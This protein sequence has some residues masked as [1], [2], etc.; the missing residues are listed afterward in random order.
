MSASIVL[1]AKDE[2]SPSMKSIQANGKSL[3]RDFDELNGKIQAL[4][5][6]NDALNKSYASLNTQLVDAKKAVKD[7][8]AAYKEAATEE[9]KTNLDKATYQ[10]KS[11]T[12]QMKTF[13][14]GSA[15]T[16]KEIRSLQE[17][18]RKLADGT[19]SGLSDGSGGMFTA[20]AKAGLGQM[21]GQSVQQYANYM[22]SS[23]FD[24]QTGNLISG[25]LGSAISGAAIGSMIPGGFGI[26]IGAAVGAASGLL[27]GVTQNESNKDATMQSYS[28]G[29][30]QTSET[31]AANDLTSGSSIAAQRQQDVLSFS[32]LLGS[33]DA[34][35]SVLG[36]IKDMANSTPYLYDDLTQIAK[37]LSVYGYNQSN[38]MQTLKTI[39][40]TGSALSMSTADMDSVA[41]IIGYLGTSDTLD[42]MR[43]KQLRLKGIN[44]NQM[45]QDY[46]GISSTDLNKR[47]SDGKISGSDAASIILKEMQTTFGGMMQQQSETFTGLT[48][49]VEGLQQ[50]IQN[51]K[52]DSFNNTRQSSLQ[53][54][55]DNLSG[56]LGAKLK[57]VNSII[58]EAEGTK[59]N[60][61]Q[62]ILEDVM[63]GVFNGTSAKEVTDQKTL[64]K[65][66]ELRSDYLSASEEYRTGD[67][68]DRMEAG[69][70]MDSIKSQAE[71]L[72]SSAQ[73]TNTKL[74]VWDQSAQDTAT[75]VASIVTVLDAWRDTW[76]L[77]QSQSKGRSA[78]TNNSGFN[79]T[80]LGD[81]SVSASSHAYG[82]S[83][84]PYD[85]FPVLLHQ[86]ERVLT[87]SDARA[88][89]N[90]SK[91]GVI[92]TITGPVTVRSDSDIPAV[93]MALADEL[94]RRAQKAG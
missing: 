89:D 47:V 92:V 48:S 83:Y 55:I 66:D 21:V 50:E 60:I 19:K 28:Q 80:G 40:D 26:P 57:S 7:A 88:S 18:S 13:K 91:N 86:G 29:L 61:E 30:T 33:S 4:Q 51:A 78:Y 20:L 70:K 5:A 68:Q 27:S 62:Q 81:W 84:V 79:D 15:D 16:R 42:S 72:A 43:L 37:T 53:D 14:D 58:G 46:Y 67:E 76:D 63:G 39:G 12:D 64:D 2:I 1:N 85:N 71:A 6:K 32:T 31:N 23:T 45:L 24:S 52:G 17:E 93:A 9:N 22:I 74:D 10:Y 59:A 54:E 35:E 65:I 77:N 69:A 38:I 73:D 49:T 44:A 90:S 25:A 87:A 94:E 56:N 34:A 3:G 8:T 36:G 75:G 11:L 82:L 41:Q